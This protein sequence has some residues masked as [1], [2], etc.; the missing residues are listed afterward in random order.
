METKDTLKVMTRNEQ[1]TTE[2]GNRKNIR[3]GWHHEA[4]A[5]VG[6]RVEREG[7][8]CSSYVMVYTLPS[9]HFLVNYPCHRRHQQDQVNIVGK[10]LHE[11]R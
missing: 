5:F 3:H 6:E 7:T 8:G 11:E 2:E 1:Q 4:P 9:P 10:Y